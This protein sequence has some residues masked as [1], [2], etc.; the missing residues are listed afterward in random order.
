MTPL[1]SPFPICRLPPSVARSP[2]YSHSVVS[3]PLARFRLPF[4]VPRFTA[5]GREFVSLGSVL[6][7][8]FHVLLPS[9]VSSFRSVPFSVYRSPFPVPRSPSYSHS[10]V[11]PAYT[12]YVSYHYSQLNPGIY[13]MSNDLFLSLRAII[14]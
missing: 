2:F 8:P 9:V 1:G 13:T 14:K 11:E 7:L 5:F 6:R 3:S 12:L 10:V 4:T